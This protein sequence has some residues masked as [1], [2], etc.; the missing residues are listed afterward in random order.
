MKFPVNTSVL[1]NG[2]AMFFAVVYPVIA[3]QQFPVKP[4]RM[5]VPSTT[6]GGTDF[7][8]RTIGQKMAEN[9][10]QPVVVENRPSAGGLIASELLLSATPD[11]HTL[12]MQSNGH[13]INASLYRKLPYDTIRDF[14]GISFVADI[15]AVL[16]A[17]PALGLKS[18]QDLIALANSKPGQINYGSAGIGRGSHINGEHFKFAAGIDVVHVPFKGAPEALTAA[19]GGSI[20]YLFAPITAV[21]QLVRSGRVTGLAVTTRNR[22]PVLPELPTVAE[23]GLTGYEFNL[24]VGLLGH[25]RMPKG[26]KERIA[27]EVARIVASTDV[28]ENLLTQGATP[29]ATSPEEFDAFIRREVESLGK[30]VKA[31][32]AR[33]D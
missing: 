21:V 5:L 32:G 3:Q 25:A 7:I 22:N 17:T 11:G 13:A 1:T 31:S 26:T 8:A 30:V 10:G 4:I 28:K 2:A 33:A 16:V 18:V 24:W 29:H 6:G 19:I 27:G 20:Q 12:M 23:A 14:A 9:W 15:P